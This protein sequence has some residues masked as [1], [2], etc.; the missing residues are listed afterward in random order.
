MAEQYIAE[1]IESST[2]QFAAQTRELNGSPPFGSFVKVGAPV[3]IIAMIYEISTGSTE[4][5]RRPVAYGK[6]EEELK[7]EQPQIFE[8]LRTEIKAM[9][10]GYSDESGMKQ[11]IPPQPPK[12]HSFVY[13]CT[14]E[15][16]QEFTCNFDYFRTLAGIGG[17]LADELMIA[18]IQQTCRVRVE[19]A[20]HYFIQAGKELA[21]LFRDDYDRLESILKRVT[22]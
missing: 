7:Y 6:T 21:R 22:I 15:E 2:T 5:N 9:I 17:T 20:R 8:L 18:A 16:V 19:S 4:L 14:L 12:L 10:V 11:L 13:T 3:T 1:I